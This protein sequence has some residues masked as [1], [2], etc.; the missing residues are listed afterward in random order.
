MAYYALVKNGA[1][2]NVIVAD[3]AFIQAHGARLAEGGQWVKLDSVKGQRPGPGWLYASG[4][5]ARPAGGV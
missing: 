2:E 1:V 3:D 4:K 5:F